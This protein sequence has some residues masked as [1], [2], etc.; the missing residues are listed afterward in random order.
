LLIGIIGYGGGLVFAAIFDL[1]AGATIVWCLAITALAYYLIS[2]SLS[3]N[4]LKQ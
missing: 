3:V 1:P 4:H 2:R